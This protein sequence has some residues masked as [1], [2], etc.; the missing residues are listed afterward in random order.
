MV[1]KRISQELKQTVGADI[2]DGWT[3]NNTHFVSVFASYCVDVP[4]RLN[5]ASTIRIEQRAALLALSPLSYLNL[6]EPET[7]S[8]SAQA[9]TFNSEVHAIFL[10]KA[11]TSMS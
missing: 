6:E 1:E 3:G 9:E 4:R 8:N 7:S 2:D 10:R 11:L 5:F